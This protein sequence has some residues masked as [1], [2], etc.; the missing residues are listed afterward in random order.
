VVPDLDVAVAVLLRAAGRT[1]PDVLAMV[2]EDLG[3][4]A[5]GTGITHR[6]EVVR[7]IGRT[8]IVADAHHALGGHAD[9]LR[10]DVIGL[11]IG[12]IDGDPELVLRQPQPVGGGKELPGVVNGVALEII[13]EAE[14]AQHLEK[15][16][17]TRSVTDVLQIIVLATGAHALLAAD[18]PGIGP[19]L[20]AQKAVLELVHAGVGEQQRRVICRHQR[21]GGDS[22]M[23]L[24]F[25]ETKEGFTYLS[26]FHRSLTTDQ[27]SRAHA[28]QS[29]T[30]YRHRRDACISVSADISIGP[31]QEIERTGSSAGD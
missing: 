1:T 7:G 22:G 31:I 12:V 8:A 25:E 26:A 28:G 30:L 27:V 20:Q 4:R 19:F 23:P 5:A 9:L 15:G 2:K 10:P 29:E 21:T 24:L 13:A 18:R 14:V 3:T 6:P 11:V 17:V 16:V